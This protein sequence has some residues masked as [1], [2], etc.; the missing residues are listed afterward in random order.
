MGECALAIYYINEFNVVVSQLN[1]VEIDF[2]DEIRALI[3]LSSLLDGW[4]TNVTI[5]SNSSESISLTFYV[6]RDLILSEEIRRREFGEPISI[7][8]VGERK[9]RALTCVGR[10]NKHK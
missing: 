10:S 2:E 9:G 6:A 4:K 8:L 5:I 1:S 3:L 7:T